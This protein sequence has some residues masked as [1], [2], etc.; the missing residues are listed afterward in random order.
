[1]IPFSANTNL[2]FNFSFF[3]QRT[4]FSQKYGMQKVSKC[5][6][7]L[8][9]IIDDFIDRGFATSISWTGV[10]RTGVV[11]PAAARTLD[12]NEAGNEE[13]PVE[14]QTAVEGADEE[15]AK[16]I[17]F[18]KYQTLIKA[19]FDVVDQASVDCSEKAVQNYLKNT[20]F[21]N[22]KGRLSH[23]NYIKKI[24]SAED[25]QYINTA[26]NAVAALHASTALA[27]NNI[28]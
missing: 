12:F 7:V 20:V 8:A 28:D 6:L 23:Q 1:M 11:K 2:F 9:S 10:S 4:L 26:I 16:K 17:V 5:N 25:Q 13:P 14:N 18:Q 24:K 19:L 22:A 15:Q 21:R 27:R 3:I